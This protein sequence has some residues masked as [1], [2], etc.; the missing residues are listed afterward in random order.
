MPGGVLRRAGHTEAAVDLARLAGCSAAGVICEVMDER[1]RDGPAA[2]AARAGRAQ[3]GLRMITIKDLIRY[4]IQKDKLVRR[5]ATTPLPTAY[6]PFTRDRLRDHGRRPRRAGAGDGRGP[7][8]RPGP[9]AHALGVPDRGRVPLPA[10]RLRGPARQGPGHHR[11][12]RARRARLPPAGGARHRAPEQDARLRAA[13]PGQGHGGGERGARLQGGPPRLRHRGADPGRPRRPLDAAPH[14]QPEEDRRAGGLRARG[15]RAVPIEVPTRRRRTASTS[16]PSTTSWAT[17]SRTAPEAA[18]AGRAPAPPHGLRSTPAGGVSP[19]SPRASTRRSATRL[20]EG[21]ARRSSDT[22]PARATSEVVWVPGAFEMPQVA[23]R[24]APRG[25]VD[26]LVCVGC[27]IRGETPHFDYVAGEAARGIAEVGRSVRRA[28]HVRADHRQHAG[29]GGGPGRRRRGEPRRG[30]GA[31]RPRAAGPVAE[32][33]AQGARA[34][35]QPARRR[36]R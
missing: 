9:G 20:V 30:G 32:L 33:A 16:G 17:S 14:Q 26:A 34:R 22:A 36:T 4:R 21:R 24:L 8:R 13:G 11:R 5:V 25:G 28:G 18:M 19:S 7:R 29:A 35:A 23:A 27:V 6:G 2:R 15:R 3:H 1:G 12:R 10:L 31:R